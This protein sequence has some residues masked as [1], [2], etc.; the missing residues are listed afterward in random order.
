MICRAFTNPTKI[1]RLATNNLSW[2]R[3]RAH[4]WPPDE[5]FSRSL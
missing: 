1:A 2:K 5:E 4:H 3:R